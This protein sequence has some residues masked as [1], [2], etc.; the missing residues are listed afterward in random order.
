MWQVKNSHDAV[1]DDLVGDED[2]ESRVIDFKKRGEGFYQKVYGVWYDLPSI[3]TS[4]HN[5]E[6]RLIRRVNGIDEL[7]REYSSRIASMRREKVRL[8]KQIQA[9]RNKAMEERASKHPPRINFFNFK[10]N[11]RIRKKKSKWSKYLSFNSETS[12]NVETVDLNSDTD[13]ESDKEESHVDLTENNKDVDLKKNSPKKKSKSRETSEITKIV[14]SILNSDTDKVSDKEE[15]HADLTENPLKKQSKSRANLSFSSETSE[16]VKVVELNSDTDSVS[17]KEENHADLT[18]SNEDVD[19]T[20]NSPKPKSRVNLSFSFENSDFPKLDLNTDTDTA[21]ETEEENHVDLTENNEE[22]DLDNNDP[23]SVSDKEEENHVDL[24]ENIED[25]DLDND[26]ISDKSDFVSECVDQILE[27]RPRRQSPIIIQEPLIPSKSDYGVGSLKVV[28]RPN[29][30]PKSAQE[31]S[32]GKI[33]NGHKCVHLAYKSST[34]S[35]LYVDT[36]KEVKAI[37]ALTKE[38]IKELEYKEKHGGT[39]S[40]TRLTPSSEAACARSILSKDIVKY[41][42]RAFTKRG[43]NDRIVGRKRPNYPKRSKVIKVN[44]DNN[45]KKGLGNVP[46]LPQ[47]PSLPTE[48][49]NL[50]IDLPTE[51][52]NLDIDYLMCSE[53]ENHVDL[54]EKNEELDIHLSE[55]HEPKMAANFYFEKESSATEKEDVS[56]VQIHAPYVNNNLKN[57]EVEKDS[58]I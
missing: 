49:K 28:I 36:E 44:Q 58:K 16:K 52:K 8:L 51:E 4:K 35:P 12:E 33:G 56:M 22:M 38:K 19:L 42:D 30:S 21:S 23:L 31:N 29:L 54:T 43:L 3:Q 18:E 41:I 15:N 48:E 50:N 45:N 55:V 2:S 25:M 39:R 57:I 47:S 10:K 20:K 13:S 6:Q 26:P 32:H 5:Q 27:D 9:R 34:F 53:E 37:V 46:S 1:Q 14:D 17:D 40:L 24:T 11:S 7:I